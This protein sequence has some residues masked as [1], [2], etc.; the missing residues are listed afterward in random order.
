M[1]PYLPVL[2]LLLILGST[3]GIPQ[4]LPNNSTLGANTHYILNYFSLKNIPST[5]TFTIDFSNA[6]IQLTQGDIACNATLNDQ[7]VASPSCSCSGSSCTL[8]PNENASFNTKVMIEFAGLINPLYLSTQK[9]SVQIY[10][11]PSI[12]E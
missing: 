8:K 7:P 10:F 1:K 12:T 11:N 3:Q 4:I 5:T 2:C 9:L 6:D